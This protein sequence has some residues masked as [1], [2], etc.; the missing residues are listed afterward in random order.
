MKINKGTNSNLFISVYWL[1]CLQKVDVES[2]SQQYNASMW[3]EVMKSFKIWP[4]KTPRCF[5]NEIRSLWDSFGFGSFE[6]KYFG[7]ATNKLR[8]CRNGTFSG[9]KWRFSK[10]RESSMSLQFHYNV[11][12]KGNWVKEIC[13]WKYYYVKN[14]ILWLHFDKIKY[15][16]SHNSEFIVLQ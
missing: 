3:N 13:L 12:W 7:V 5:Q 6:R 10:L 4:G 8:F 9:N 15:L 16:T 11:R 2:Y 14:L 1:I